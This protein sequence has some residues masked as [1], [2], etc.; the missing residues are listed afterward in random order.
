MATP[1]IQII[2][3]GTDV[4][5][6][7]LSGLLSLTITDGVGHDYDNVRIDI[8]DKDGVIAPPEK[9]AELQ[10]SAGY[11][12]DIQDFGTFI[13][14]Q[15]SLNGWPQVISVTARSLDGL[16]EAKQGRD[17]SYRKEDYPSYRDIFDEL[18]DRM[19]LSLALSNE[20]AG[21]SVEFESQFGESDVTFASR[22]GR[23]LDAAVSVKEGRLIVVPRG[24][25]QSASSSS[26]PEIQVMRPG[27]VLSYNVTTVNVPKHSTVRAVWFD[28]L[29]G[30]DKE[31]V[32]QASEEGPE[33]LL[34][35]NFQ[36][37]NDA[38]EQ[39][40]ATAAALKRGEGQA[41]FEI[42]G[43]PSARAESYVNVSGIRSLVDGRW[44]CTT[45]THVFR[46]DGPY[47]TQLI[48]EATV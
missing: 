45:A 33:Y 37:E 1:R 34:R 2:A 26:L 22:L 41:T 16:S 17:Q 8:D 7:I 14:D 36:N 6:N 25:G 40:R 21:K 31:V 47:T 24:Q 44:R 9:G 28:R 32:V 10:V 39:A 3:D 38:R 20:I 42:D 12:D 30:V 43:E 15:V 18:A 11:E 13:V 4:T 19:G 5:G 48:C 27:N 29:E 23:K 46:G 35:Q